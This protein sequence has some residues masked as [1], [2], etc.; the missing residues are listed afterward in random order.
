MPSCPNCDSDVRDGAKFCTSCGHRFP[1]GE[2]AASWGGAAIT[3]LGFRAA[4]GLE[5]VSDG[6]A[7]HESWPAAPVGATSNDDWAPNA[8][9]SDPTEPDEPSPA[10]SETAGFWPESSP[11]AWPAV[12]PVGAAGHAENE[13]HGGNNEPAS[14]PGSE[15][16]AGIVGAQTQA[17]E[18]LDQLRAAIVAIDPAGSPDLTGV[19]SDLEVAATPPGAIPSD[20]LAALRE[21]IFA[22][23]ENPRDIDTIVDLT[24]RIDGLAAL[25]IAYDRA[26]AAIERSLEALKGAEQSG[27]EPPLPPAASDEL[28][29]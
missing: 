12:A 9:N 14:N 24:R 27:E 17:L 11:D 16:G 10:T 28:S 19:V 3:N 22:A 13:T 25:V 21:A 7:A 2:E 8:V 6:E 20:D 29:V 4:P 26:I 5:A 23:R 18:L 15:A 1:E